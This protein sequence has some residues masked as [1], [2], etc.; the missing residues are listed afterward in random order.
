LIKGLDRQRLVS[1]VFLGFS[2]NDSAPSQSA[3]YSAHGVLGSGARFS[4]S[5]GHMTRPLMIS[6]ARGS[7]PLLPP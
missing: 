6:R 4:F 5:L 2:S 3:E 7:R 1:G